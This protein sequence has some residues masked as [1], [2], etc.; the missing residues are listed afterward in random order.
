[1]AVQPR[2]ETLGHYRLVSLLG[3]GGMARV[4]LAEHAIIGKTVAIKTLLPQFVL[5]REARDMLVREATITASIRH[6]N[7]IDVYDFDTDDYGKPYFVMELAAGETLEQRLE[8]GAMSLAQCLDIA[9]R[10]ADAV[11][12]IHAAG[13]LHRDI[14]PQ[15]VLLTSN[16]RRTIP[17]LIDFG[18]A[19][20]L[21][22]GNDRPDEGMV[23][24]PR[25]MAPEQISQDHIDERTDIWAL[26]VLFYQML[27]GRMPFSTGGTVRED[28][29]AIVTEQPH[30]LPRVLTNNVRSI[31]ES[32]L[33]KDPE[34]RPPSAAVLVD[35]LRVA[36]SDHLARKRAIA[37]IV[38]A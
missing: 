4:H 22:P 21:D 30:P 9:V 3:E 27:T 10:L 2:R 15:N 18:I 11:A 35:Q 26:G 29:V 31:V 32:C 34:D 24:T 14:K 38:G 6:P 37:R 8:A 36:L 7:V 28:L 16:G 20:A 25:A 5:C 13:F 33:C 19:K 23:G 12:A 17:K 1:V